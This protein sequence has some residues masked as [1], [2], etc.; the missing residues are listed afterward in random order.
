MESI[1]ITIEGAQTGM[2]RHV[3]QPQIFGKKN[4]KHYLP[5]REL[6]LRVTLRAHHRGSL[7]ARHVAQTHPIFTF[8]L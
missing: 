5:Q 2:F 1:Y 4:S 7:N 6:F 8:S 3:S